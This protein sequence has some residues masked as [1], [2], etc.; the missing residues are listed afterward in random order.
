MPAKRKY[1]R[2]ASATSQGTTTNAAQEEDTPAQEVA[3]GSVP[4]ASDMDV[5]GAIQLLTQIVATQAQREGTS[6]VHEMAYQLKDVANTLYEIWEES[7][8]EDADPSTKKEFADAFLEHFLPIKV[9]EA[10]ALE[11]ERLRQNDMS[12]NE[13]YLKF[14]SLAKY[15]PEMVRDM[16]A[17]VR[18][19]VLGL[20]DDL[21]A[22]ANIAAQNNDMTITKMVDFVQGNEDR[23]KEEERQQGHFLRDC[24]STKQNNGGN[25][26]QSTNSAAHHN[27]QVEQG[28]G[29]A[30]SNNVG[31]GRNSLYALADRQDTEARGDVVTE[32]L[33]EPFEVFTPVGESVIARCI[34]MGCPV[35]VH[36][37]LT[38]ADL[39]ELEM[40]DFDV[41]MGMDWLESCYAKVGC[42]TKIVSFEFPGE[43][44]LEWKGD[45]VTPRGRF[46]SYLKARKKIS[47]GYIYHLVRVKDTDAEIP[48]LQS[49]PIVNEFPEV[50]PED[51]PGVPPDREIN[52]GIDLLPGTKP[53][54]IPPYRMAPID[55]KELKV[56]SET[57]HAEHLR[58]VLQTLQDHKLYAKFS[59]C[60]FWL[61]SVAFLG[62]VISGEGV[63]VDFQKIE[64]VKNWPRPTSVSDIRSFLG[65]ARYYRHFVEHGKVIAYVSRQ[66]KAHEKN[67]PTHDLELAA[68]VFAL[69]IWRHYLYGVYVDIFIDHK[70]LQYI[71]KQ[72]K[73]N[74]RQRR[75]LEL[76]KDYDVDILYHTGK[77]N[78]V[79]DALSRRS[80][81]RLAHVK[82]DKRPMMKEVHRLSNLGVQLLDSEDSGVVLQN[83]VES[84]LVAEVKEK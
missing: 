46:I 1:T 57:D 60:E 62:Y 78:V 72:R 69:K 61:R 51:L 81:G 42:R 6:D 75:W 30:K 59:K 23:L 3:P 48:T 52:F 47:K 35:K 83:R 7:R 76:L 56:Y 44:V 41:I 58:I 14:V 18:R 15:A 26:A 32:K 40:L 22:D 20:S 39:V 53:I 12:V 77:A 82:A 67:Y 33:C 19:F 24:P 21:I 34:Y 66:L 54:S 25:V 10:K 74:L 31:S 16:R 65:L 55:L 49:V 45:A 9:L 70:S 11:F 13:Y 80:M 68:V 36:H 17:R 63:K 84:S 79:A 2:R 43:P 8:E 71:F 50:F 64:V 4:S 73:L 27:S 5:R 28:R 38:V 29:A 37:R